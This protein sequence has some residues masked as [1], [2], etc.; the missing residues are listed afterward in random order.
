MR[1]TF[2]NRKARIK[3]RAEEGSAYLA[4]TTTHTFD[5]PTTIDDQCF[6][7]AIIEAYISHGRAHR[8]CFSRGNKYTMKALGCGLN[9]LNPFLTRTIEIR[10]LC[11]D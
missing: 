4:N 8:E 2:N 11:M 5:G 7:E 3:Y 9:V 6:C 10:G 1:R